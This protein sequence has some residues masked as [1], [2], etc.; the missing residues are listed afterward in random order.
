MPYANNKDADQPAH[1]RRF[2]RD[3]ARAFAVRTHEVW[4]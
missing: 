1:P 4:K 2:S 3:V